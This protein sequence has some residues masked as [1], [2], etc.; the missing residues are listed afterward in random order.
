MLRTR[1]VWA[2][3][4]YDFSCEKDCCVDDDGEFE[5][6]ECWREELVL[7][8]GMNDGIQLSIRNKSIY[9]VAVMNSITCGRWTKIS[10]ATCIIMSAALEEEYC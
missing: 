8:S 3:D 1:E 6:R 5:A 9:F 4:V 2:G 10:G 7:F